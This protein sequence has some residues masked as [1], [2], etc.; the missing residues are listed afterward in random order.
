MTEGSGTGGGERGKPGEKPAVTWG[1]IERVADEAERDEGKRLLAMSDEELDED[2]AE[3]G[4]EPGE[5][6]DVMKAA[7]AKAPREGA[8]AGASPDASASPEPPTKVVSLVVERE[9]RRRPRAWIAITASAAAAAVAV[10]IGGG[11]GG[12]LVG[13][14]DTGQART[15][16]PAQ[17]AEIVAGLASHRG[18][19]LRLV[20]APD[21]EA[22]RFCVQLA[23]ALTEAGWSVERAAPAADSEVASGVAIAVERDA[24]D[25][26]WGAAAELG[27]VLA[28]ARV[29]VSGPEQAPPGAPLTL[30]VGPR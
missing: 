19:A 1:T 14:G 18:Q 21:V 5:A 10:A 24:N 12:A 2:L 15:L 20:C 30:R 16:T 6:L 25:G 13:H 28:R 7:L 29:E 17:R 27:V 8:Q 11:G 9:K 3:D 26:S 23:S 22:D 4:I